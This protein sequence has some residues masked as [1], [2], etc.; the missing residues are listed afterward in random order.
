MTPLQSILRL[1][2]VFA[3]LAVATLLSISGRPAFAAETA[4]KSFDIPAGEARTALKRFVTQSGE[5]LLYAL[6]TVEGVRTQAVK[7]EF[8]AREALGR[9]VSGTPLA[10]VQDRTNGSF[11]LVRAADPNAPRAAQTRSD[12]PL[13]NA[14]VKAASGPTA[15]SSA[16]KDAIVL[17]PYEVRTDQDTG[18]AAASSLAGGRLATDLRD[19]PAAYSV[20]TREFIDALGI[21][22]LQEAADWSTGNTIELGQIGAGIFFSTVYS[23]NTRGFNSIGSRPQRNFFPQFHNADSYNIERYDFGRGP[24]SILF[25]NG[26]LGG[27][28]SSTTKRA[29][30]DKAI[31]TVQTSIGSWQNYRA[32]LDVNQPLGDKVAV[33]AVALWGDSEGWR[34][35]DFNRKK[36]V[37]LT[38]TFKPFK[39]T[40]IRLEGEYLANPLVVG[41]HSIADEFSGWDGKTTYNSVSP[42]ATL[43]ANANALGISRRPANYYVYNPLAPMKAILSYQN[44]PITIS[45]GA[46][47]TTPI[48]GFVQG[49]AAPFGVSGA[50]T[51]YQPNMPAGRF[52]NAIGNSFFRP[53]SEEFTASPDTPM[54]THRFQDV[55]LTM[56]HHLA[57]SLFFE[58]AADLNRTRIDSNGERPSSVHIDINR[59][60]PDGSP[61]PFFLQPYRDNQFTHNNFT[62]TQAGLR[63]AAAYVMK[64]NRFGRFTFNTLGGYYYGRRDQDYRYLSLAQGNDHRQWGFLQ[65]IVL[66]GV[67]YRHYM[68]E[69]NRPW[70]DLAQAPI[71]FVDPVNGI[72]QVIQPRWLPDTTRRDTQGIDGSDF[73]YMLASVNAKF[74]KDRLVVLGAVRRD[75]YKFV[76]EQ[77]L[78]KGDYPVDWDGLNRILRP[79][80][81][82]DYDTLTY[83]PLTAS[84]APDGPKLPARIRP[85]DGLGNR[86]PRYLNALF[87]DDYNVPPLNGSQVTRSV[88]SVLHLYSWFNPSFNYAETFNPPTSAFVTLNGTLL[89]A[90]VAK[91]KDYGLRMELFNNRL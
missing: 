35:K 20:I 7:G 47:S 2:A 42:L 77:Q 33:R 8:S 65:S 24:N 41:I 5:Q 46:T 43:P 72:N 44:E 15:R 40:E 70:V 56:S 74:L 17:S 3:A 34:M 58:V 83:Q 68:N 85:R 54:T 6:E 31:K 75:T 32:E 80:A 84:G 61:N 69:T 1:R 16:K 82:A 53:F 38:S 48:G 9:M 89:P 87:Q 25:G 4:R 49:S 64:P 78:D 66:Q 55:Q 14:P 71:T 52:D 50:P 23:Y 91:G 73:K 39:N 21:T 45:G 26:T 51:L 62:F 36:G 67:R 29:R 59:I 86:D 28:P 30:T 19:T 88:G 12:R 81:P 79:S 18:F 37:F 57:E 63:G 60:L 11:S 90:S 27:I 22:N 10:V 13:P 76:V